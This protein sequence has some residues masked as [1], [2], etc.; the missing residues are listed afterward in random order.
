[1]GKKIDMSK[2]AGI[3][4][5]GTPRVTQRCVDAL[6][7]VLAAGERVQS[8]WIWSGE[9]G[10]QGGR[11]CGP[12]GGAAASR[13]VSAGSLFE[14]AV[15]RPEAGPRTRRRRWRR[16]WALSRVRAAGARRSP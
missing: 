3:E 4:Y 7:S 16:T 2:L 1:M 10:G 15:G 11:R 6:K 5:H 9:D 14:A 12:T 8:A 13:G